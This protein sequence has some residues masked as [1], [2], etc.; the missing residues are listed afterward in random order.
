MKQEIV[1]YRSLHMKIRQKFLNKAVIAQHREDAEILEKFFKYVKEKAVQ[2]ETSSPI[3]EEAF[4]TIIAAMR[5]E[6]GRSK[7]DWTRLLK[8]GGISFEDSIA[9]LAQLAENALAERINN[10]TELLKDTTINIEEKF[11]IN[12]RKIGTKTANIFQQTSV[13]IEKEIVDNINQLT[14][15]KVKEL[16]GK[17][18]L[19]SGIVVAVSGKTD[20]QGNKG[21][22]IQ[23][24][25]DN[26]LDLPTR[27]LY[28]LASSNFSLKNYSSLRKEEDKYIPQAETLIALG[29][30]TLY[31]ALYSVLS[32]IG[33]PNI[34]KIIYNIILNATEENSVDSQKHLYHLRY[35]YELTGAGL[36]YTD[37]NDHAPVDFFL[38]N[39]PHTTMISVKSTAAMIEEEF[40]RKDMQYGSALTKQ[41]N[42]KRIN[43]ANPYYRKYI[44]GFNY[45]SK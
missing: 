20:I 37:G 27:I 33:M 14:D 15:Q 38:Y 13:Q 21:I 2:A 32:Y 6:S 7:F 40:S 30:S 39:D 29:G 17:Q 44:Q 31:R 19:Q 8:S 23:L 45:K 25:N 4:N 36:K 22:T 41:L 24:K 34:N 12:Q 10:E 9:R 1:N 35:I 28:L 26:Q 11:S 3:E 16:F 5:Y 18:F 43:D 42:I